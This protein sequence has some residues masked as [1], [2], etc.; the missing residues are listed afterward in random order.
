MRPDNNHL[1]FCFTS[2]NYKE[3]EYVKENRYNQCRSVC[4][5]TIIP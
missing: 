5:V 1:R 4:S 2:N 3:I